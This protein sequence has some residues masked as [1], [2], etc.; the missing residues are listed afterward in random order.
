MWHQRAKGKEVSP[1]LQSKTH[2]F[3][4]SFQ[5]ALLLVPLCESNPPL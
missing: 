3:F 1:M 2:L 4:L 5:R